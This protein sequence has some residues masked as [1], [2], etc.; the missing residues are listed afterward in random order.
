MKFL[1]DMPI[2]PQVAD[3]LNQNGHEAVHAF[4]VGLSMAF[5]MAIIE[6]AYRHKE[7]VVT[8]DLDYPRIL[9]LTKRDGP[10]IILFRGGNYSEHEM[11]ELIKR[12]IKVVPLEDL[13]KN[14]V[15]ADKTRIRRII[16]PIKTAL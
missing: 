13:P 10:G 11:R 1:V 5:D 6:R 2:S 14:I 4:D 12:V 8:A 7:V 3:W 15:V 16:L 9:A